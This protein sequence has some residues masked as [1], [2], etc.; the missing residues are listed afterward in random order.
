MP[1]GGVPRGVGAG[2]GLLHCGD[3]REVRARQVV[4]ATG[5]WTDDV[6]S[7][8]GRGR[9][10]VRASKGVHLV[11][12]RDRIA[13]DAGIILRTPTSVLFVIPWP[14]VVHIRHWIVGTTDTD[15]ELG[16]SHPAASAADITYLL[17]Q[18]NRVLRQPLGPADVEGVYAGLR[19]L[20]HGESEATSRL[21]REHAV[22]QPVAGLLTVAGG[23]YTTYRV[24]ARDAVDM[25]A[26]N[27]DKRV[28]DSV[29]DATPLVGATGFHAA[30]NR[31]H[32]MAEETGL[33]VERIE[34]L[35]HR[36]GS[37]VDELLDL[38]A[39]DPDLRQ[40]LPGAE[41]H[42]AVEVVYAASHEGALHLDD[43]LTRRTR[44]SIETFDRGVTAAED[45]AR[46]MARVLGWDDDTIK[47]EVEH[48]LLRVAAERESQTMADD[49]TADATRLGAPEV[50]MGARP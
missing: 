46:L 49:A 16:K 8:A 33:H 24:M 11:V 1:R 26:R 48:Y 18:A 50:R 10:K 29:T 21:S 4:N 20:L 5:V 31:R 30:W 34:H 28:P 6:Q 36:Y 7:W 13:A 43:V 39:D 32:R 40:P 17:N 37:R 3:E 25:L 15:W 45:A 38:A 23:K 22:N 27:L 35:L 42:L 9:I 12:P 44:V 19:P 41:D 2:P 47:R 14:D